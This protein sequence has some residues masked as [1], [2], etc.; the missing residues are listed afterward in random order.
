MNE[1]HCIELWFLFLFVWREP[2]TPF[3]RTLPLASVRE[4]LAS[5]GLNF[6]TAS[7]APFR[8]RCFAELRGLLP[9]VRA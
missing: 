7:A 5:A 9:R 8:N 4:G 1:Y 2:K 6:R 3:R